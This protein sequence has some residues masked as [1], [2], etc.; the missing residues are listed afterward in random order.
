MIVTNWKECERKRMWP[1]LRYHVHICL[2]RLKRTTKDL[3][4]YSRSPIQAMQSGPTEHE[5]HW[6]KDHTQPLLYFSFIQGPV[7]RE[8]PRIDS[9]HATLTPTQHNLIFPSSC[10]TTVTQMFVVTC[11]GL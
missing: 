4:P 2:R 3:I 9:V 10:P 1:N 7:D 5:G 11:I 6:M 8:A